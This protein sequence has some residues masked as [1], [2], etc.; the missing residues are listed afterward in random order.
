MSLFL[1]FCLVEMLLKYPGEN[2][3]KVVACVDVEGKQGLV[4]AAG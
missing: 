1:D 2:V 4:M 3:E